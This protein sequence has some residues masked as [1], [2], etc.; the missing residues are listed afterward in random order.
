[1][2]P[3][4]IAIVVLGTRGDLEP[5]LAL[6]KALRARQ[7]D[8][9][10]VGFADLQERT[11]QVGIPF[12]PIPGGIKELLASAGGQE[13]IGSRSPLSFMRAWRKLGAELVDE[14]TPVLDSALANA[15]QV[16]LCGPTAGLAALTAKARGIP[17]PTTCLQPQLPTRQQPVF[18]SPIA[19]L[20]PLNRA[21]WIAAFRMQWLVL[22]P[23][24]DAACRHYDLPTFANFDAFLHFIVDRTALNA[25]SPTIAQP[26][27]DWPAG[28][29]MTGR[30][31][32][33]DERPMSVELEAFLDAGDAP[34]YVGLGSMVVDDPQQT[35]AMLID[36]VRRHRRR[37]VISRGWAG[38]GDHPQQ[39]DDILVISDEPHQRLFLRCAAVLH[40]AG[41]GT[42]QAV[43]ASGT[44]S[45]PLPF[46][47]DQPFWAR[48]L[49]TLGIAGTPVRRGRWT[50]ERIAASLGE[51]LHPSAASRARNVA[52][53]MGREE[54]GADTAAVTILRC[55][56]LD[57]PEAPCASSTARTW[58]SP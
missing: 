37:I 30:W 4:R 51:V 26:S 44:P 20:G 5:H 48:R 43:A 58:V 33:D 11:D 10:V 19:N 22:K 53:Q 12:T 7:A 54:V 45:V 57:Q 46:G 35:T 8:A 27:S 38:L 21:S 55:Q 40:H 16:V 41:A 1:M 29:R 39:D 2:T 47:V 42:S 31:V 13:F 3:P 18:I 32:L 17:A 24:I 34:V 56:P 23:M 36:A 15:D 14:V 25:W 28:A 52:A 9:H 49:H 50:T 6:A